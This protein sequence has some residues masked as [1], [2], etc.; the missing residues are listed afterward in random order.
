MAVMLLRAVVSDCLDKTTQN[1]QRLHY[2][3]T[4]T[5]Y[6]VGKKV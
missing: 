1:H 4:H 6:S 5:G 3:K 2:D